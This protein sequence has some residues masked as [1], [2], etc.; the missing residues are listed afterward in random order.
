VQATYYVDEGLITVDVPAVPG[1]D[2]PPASDDDTGSIG[3]PTTGCYATCDHKHPAQTAANTPVTDT[4]GNFTGDDVEAVL[5]EL[6]DNIDG[7]SG[8]VTDHGALTGLLDDDHTQYQKESEKGAVSGYA[9][10]DASG[11]IEFARLPVG[12]TPGTVSEGNHTHSNLSGGGLQLAVRDGTNPMEYVYLDGTTDPAYLDRSAGG[13]EAAVAAHEH[14]SY[15]RGESDKTYRW[16]AG[17]LEYS[18]GTWALVAGN[19]SSIHVNSV[20]QDSTNDY[21]EVNFDT[22][23]KVI[24]AFATADEQ[25]VVEGYM[26]GSTSFLDKIRIA[27][28]RDSNGD[29]TWAR[30]DPATAPPTGANIWFD[31][32]LEV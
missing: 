10:L 31:A 30:I 8:S 14:T 28:S 21:I 5:A 18:A 29:G 3:D 23:T 6:Q 11:D 32:V 27:I 19:H 16:V 7:V 24:R 2:P 22:A 17:V 26:V 4:A 12:T 15:L 20:T 9:P 13:A 1:D 25:F